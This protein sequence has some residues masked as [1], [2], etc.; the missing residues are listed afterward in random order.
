MKNLGAYVFPDVKKFLRKFPKK[1]LFILSYGQL[2]FQKSKIKGAGIEKLVSKIFVTKRKKIAVILELAQKYAFSKKEAIILI[3]DHPEQF[4][5]SRRARK[6]IKTFYLSRK[7]GRYGDLPCLERDYAVKNLKE[8]A[9]II[10]KEK[11]Q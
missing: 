4:K 1:D 5:M 2:K 11:L 3:D 9:R 8:V 7:E 10:K 6:I